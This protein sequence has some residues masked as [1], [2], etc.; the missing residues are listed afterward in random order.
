MNRMI[1][2]EQ[3]VQ[4]NIYVLTP[5]VMNPLPRRVFFFISE[6]NRSKSSRHI[7][8]IERIVYRNIFA[9]NAIIVVLSSHGEIT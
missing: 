6:I 2:I 1:H 8:R 7:L 3:W 9:Y 5:F 4:K